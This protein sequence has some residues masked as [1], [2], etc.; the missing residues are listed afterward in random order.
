MQV[1]GSYVF[2]S[3]GSGSSSILVTD[4]SGV[5]VK[6]ITN[7]P[8]ADGMVLSRDGTSL[9]VALSGA[10]AVSVIDTSTLTETAR[11]ATGPSTCPNSV[12]FAGGKIWFAYRCIGGSSIGSIDTSTDPATVDTGLENSND[13]QLLSTG[14]GNP[15]LLVVQ[16]TTA[17]VTAG[18]TIYNVS[19]GTLVTVANARVG[20][21]SL[22]DIEISPDG[23]ELY[24]A[25]G[26]PYYVQ[27]LSTSE[28]SPVGQYSTGGAYPTAV[29]LSPDG[30]VVATGC[31]GNP[32]TY[33]Y[34]TGASAAY[35]NLDFSDFEVEPDG[36]VFAPDDSTLFVV[37][38][39]AA[40]GSPPVLHIIA[41]PEKIPSTI[42]LTAPSTATL[43]APLTISGTLS[44]SQGTIA[45]P[46]TLT[47]LKDDLAGT[48]ALPDVTTAPDGTFSFNDTPEVGTTNTYTV[49]WAGGSSDLPTSAHSS[50]NVTRHA[51]SIGLT[52]NASLYNYHQVATVTAHLGTTSNSRLV[53][54]YAQPRGLSKTLIKAGNV[55]RSGNLSAVYQLA[56]D[57][58]FTV[59]FSGDYLYGPASTARSVSTRAAVTGKL[60]Y[61]YATSSGYYLYHQKTNPV[62]AGLVAP[63]KRGQS[64]CFRLQLYYRGAWVPEFR[65]CYPMNAKSGAVITIY[66]GGGSNGI[67]DHLRIRTEYGGDSL[68]QG[69]DSPWYYYLFTT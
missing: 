8:G 68:N 47:V 33:L 58:T 38:T 67:G 14:P 26:Y 59:V 24:I 11:Y 15:N 43:G 12:G 37:S 2:I 1:T 35:R 45:S 46:Q 65:V 52:T 7:E 4:Y 53:S 9:Y 31:L 57:T 62:V 25:Q 17:G 20:S 54:I 64:V 49:S 48:H 27:V 5:T 28:L 60:H 32:E 63:N 30:K 16:G 36:M 3:S 41:T 10:D 39:S 55:N 44:L 21:G 29:A 50:V 66:P 51:T 6:T 56:R 34:T 69:A 61:S 13:L 22:G 19:S 42:G 18:V 40:F 23:S